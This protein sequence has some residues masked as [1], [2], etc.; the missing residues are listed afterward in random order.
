MLQNDNQSHST[1]EE[2]KH[3]TCLPGQQNCRNEYEFSDIK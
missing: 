3:V 1:C 2:N